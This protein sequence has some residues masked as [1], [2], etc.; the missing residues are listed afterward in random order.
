MMASTLLCLASAQASGAI[1]TGSFG[2][3]DPS[4]MTNC[5]GTYYVYSTGGSMLYSTDRINWN[6]GTSPF[7]KGVPTSVAS[8]I[9]SNQGIWAPDVIY[10]NNIYYLYYAVADTTGTQ[11]AIGLMTS[12]TLNPSATNYHWTDQGIVVH[13][14]DD[15]DKISAIDPCPFFDAS[16]A[17]WMS[18]GSGYANGATWSDP[19]IFIIKLNDS[20]GLASTTNTG[21]YPVALGHI[22]G[23]YVYYHSG[24]YYAFWNSGGCCSGTNSTYTIHVARSPTVTGTYVDQYGNT[25]SSDT[26]LAATVTKN[27]IIGAEHGPGQL[28]ILCEGGV[29]YCTY[30]YYPE[31]GGGAVLGEET[32]VW[33]ANGWPIAG[34]D[35]VP[36]TYKITASGTNSVLGIRGANSTNG[37][38]IE[39]EPYTA[40][41]YQQWK[42]ANTYS[43]GTTVDG[44]Y[45][46]TSIGSAKAMDLYQANAAN[47]TLIDEWAPGTG[48]NQRWFI[49]ETSDGN[50][51]ILSRTSGSV[52]SVPTKSQIPYPTVARVNNGAD[53]QI[54][55]PSQF[56]WN[57]GVATSTDLKSWTT[58]P[59]LA[60]T[61]G[62][63][64]YTETGAGG[65]TARF[66]QLTAQQSV[67]EW[68]WQDLPSQEWLFSAP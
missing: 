26:F 30:H 59:T 16:G 53:A 28:G 51:R 27:A 49:E 24:Y 29:Y 44:Y 41:T 22:E 40:S 20:T 68:T 64:S 13:R 57:Y 42:I 56:G 21:L 10:L 47:G 17:L 54:S 35:I 8:V 7:P 43:S 45:S 6:F 46:I 14:H 4:R 36:G 63:M 34:A 52:V 32:L 58:L 39:E 50:F 38:S 37:T 5:D 12:P 61:G 23:S 48:N 25:D 55:F 1:L 11:S 9:P 33:G 62:A 65:N 2:S 31:S 3:H 15:Q 67:D 19:T 66:W 60:G 18:Y